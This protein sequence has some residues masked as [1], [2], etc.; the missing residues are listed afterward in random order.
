M[1]AKAAGFRLRIGGGVALW[2][3]FARRSPPPPL[4]FPRSP[5]ADRSRFLKSHFACIASD[6]LPAYTPRHLTPS[7]AHPTY[8]V[9]LPAPLAFAHRALVAAE[10][11]ALAAALILRFFGCDCFAFGPLAFAHRAF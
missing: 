10:I 2:L 3:R 4:H 7:Q 6:A 1:A 9:F 5:T 11:L 8:K